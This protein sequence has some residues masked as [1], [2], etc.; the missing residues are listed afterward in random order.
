MK[1]IFV[2]PI[3]VALAACASPQQRC[4][5]GASKDLNIVQ[6]LIS[7]TEATIARGYAI[8]TTE[9]QLIYTDFCIGHGR[10]SVGVTWCNRSQPVIEKTPIAVDLDAERRKLNDLRVKEAE[11]R[12]ST[13]S[14]VQRCELAHL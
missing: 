8:Q 3:I 10:R 4:V 2:F 5:D 6:A 13:A 14:E 11:L 7:D 1:S 12:S 9:R